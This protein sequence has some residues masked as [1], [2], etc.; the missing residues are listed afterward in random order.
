MGRLVQQ[1]AVAGAHRQH[2]ACTSRSTILRHAGRTT[3]GS[4]TQ[5]KRS[6]AIPGRF[7]WLNLIEFGGLD[8]QGNR[9]ICV[10]CPDCATF[11]ARSRSR[12]APADAA[13]V[14][15]WLPH[16]RLLSSKL[17]KKASTNLGAIQ[18]RAVL[19]VSQNS[20]QVYWKA[21]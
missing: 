7:S 15:S 3:H 21:L 14:S 4:I 13:P 10:R 16:R 9:S 17:G 19:P 1:Q 18:L 20:M 8:E 11:G 6:P 12:T 5:S 2:P